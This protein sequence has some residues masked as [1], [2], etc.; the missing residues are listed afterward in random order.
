MRRRSGEHLDEYL[1]EHG[2]GGAL[3][4]MRQHSICINSSVSG[5]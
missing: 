2:C 4:G 3:W 1:D 5:S